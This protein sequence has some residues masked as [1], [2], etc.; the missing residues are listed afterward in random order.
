MGTERKLLECI[1]IDG[2]IIDEV[3]FIESLE[4]PLTEDEDYLNINRTRN[5]ENTSVEDY[6][7][8]GYCMN[9]FSWYNPYRPVIEEGCYEGMVEWV[10][11]MRLSWDMSVEEIY[12]TLLQTARDQ[13]LE[14]FGDSVRLITNPYD[15]NDGEKLVVYKVGAIFRKNEY[16]EEYLGHTDFH[17]KQWEGSFWTDKPGSADIRFEGFA[18]DEVIN[19]PWEVPWWGFGDGY[20]SKPIFFAVRRS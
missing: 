14:D 5:C 10:E 13:I 9:T 7:C 20:N 16:N 15:F 1:T 19:K 17:F 6:N 12:D 11:D 8:G 2:A 3:D 4:D 18:F